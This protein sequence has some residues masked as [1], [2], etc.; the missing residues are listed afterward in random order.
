[1]TFLNTIQYNTHQPLADADFFFL[2]RAASN[3]VDSVCTSYAISGTPVTY[4]KCDAIAN[5]FEG[6][7]GWQQ[8]IHTHT[9]TYTHD[10]HFSRLRRAG[11]QR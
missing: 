9:H 1:M 6:L 5:D 3:H 7:I 11:L 10:G 2:L 4:Y 8:N